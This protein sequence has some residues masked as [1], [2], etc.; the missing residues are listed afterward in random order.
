MASLNS[1]VQ[2]WLPQSAVGGYCRV[3]ANMLGTARGIEDICSGKGYRHHNQK[4]CEQNSKRG[5]ILCKVVFEH[6]WMQHGLRGDGTYSPPSTLPNFLDTWSVPGSLYF[7][8]QQSDAGT[9]DELPD[10]GTRAPEKRSLHGVGWLVGRLLVM[11]RARDKY[12]SSLITFALLTSEGMSHGVN[13]NILLLTFFF[14]RR[15]RRILS[16]STN[17]R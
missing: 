2:L 9:N 15:P 8:P 10:W 11:T 1:F 3:C 12:W 16:P 6:G 14:T 7:F 5:C 13:F 4:K 17:D